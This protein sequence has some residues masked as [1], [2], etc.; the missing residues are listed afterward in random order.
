MSTTETTTAHPNV[1]ANGN[2]RA[3]DVERIREQFPILRR[4]INGK[5]LVYLDNAATTQKPQVVIDRV[6]DY[7][8]N[9]NA[10]IHRGVHTLSQE[11]TFAY[12]AARK[13][14][15][16]FIG[17]ADDREVV[18][19]RGC[20]E[21]I[22]LV[23]S[24]WGSQNIGEGDE[25]IVST[26]EHHANIVPWQML[27]ERVGAKLNVIPINDKGELLLDEYE[28]LLSDR[29]KLVAVVHV[30]NALGTINPVEDI[31]RLAKQHGAAVL[32][33]GAQALSHHHVD[34]Q[35]IGC[36]FYTASAHKVF[37]PTGIGFVW[38]KAEHL[39]AMPPWQGGGDMI[40][41][42]TFEKTTYDSYPGKFE[43]GT[44][45]IVGG[46]GFDT[47]LKF[48]KDVGIDAI[49]AHEQDLLEYATAQIKEIEGIRILGEADNKA[50][51]LSFLVGDIHPHDAGTLL[52]Q[53]GIAVRTGHHCTQPLWQR[54]QVPAACRAS[55]SVYNTRDEVDAFIA[56]VKKVQKLFG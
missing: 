30:S 1:A 3:F 46:L 56:G 34:V 15:S 42:V 36:D 33:D 14:V 50:A 4:Q 9:E 55:F 17:A 25:I 20:T 53:M 13:T 45:N 40:D 6:R 39:D 37:G 38:G 43:A 23:A 51:V 18:F 2:S 22:N 26:M 54:F 44:P 29:T 35:A 41:L 47:A 10:N 7:Y 49:A 31:T 11:G 21:G 52:D 12:E 5:P 16:D 24:T 48:T 27:C 28:K 19:V 32:I 8:S